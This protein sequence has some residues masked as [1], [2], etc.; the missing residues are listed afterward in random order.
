MVTLAPELPG[1]MDLLREVVAAGAIAA[2][3][4]T[5]ATHEQAET[6]FASGARLATHLFNA[7]RSFH[8]RAPGPAGAAL[9]DDTVTCELINDGIHVHEDAVRIALTAAGAERIAL[10]T[11][12]TPAAGMTDGE[13]VL[14]DSR[15]TALNLTT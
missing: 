13:G 11:D 8:H 4:H 5:D 7:M 15:S 3:G 10:I 9:A 6:A 2:V 12:A 14:L 1:G